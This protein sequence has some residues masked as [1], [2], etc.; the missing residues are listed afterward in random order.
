MATVE[1]LIA[2]VRQRYWEN[3]QE[4]LLPAPTADIEQLCDWVEERFGAPVPVD[5]IAFWRLADG[6]G[7]NGMSLDSPL[8]VLE[9]TE[10]YVDQYPEYLMIGSYEDGPMYTYNMV[11]RQF[12]TLEQFNFEEGP[13]AVYADFVD[14]LEMAVGVMF[15]EE[16]N[17]W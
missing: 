5:L 9:T 1:S 6:C 15:G 13:R 2:Q 16:W 10:L 7:M 3:W 4:E 14:L 12:Q 8:E 17:E 11:A